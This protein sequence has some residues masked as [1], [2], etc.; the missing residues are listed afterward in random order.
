MAY[1]TERGPA[2]GIDHCEILIVEGGQI[3]PV[4]LLYVNSI[5]P[6]PQR[7]DIRFE[8]DDKSTT[9]TLQSGIDVTVTCDMQDIAAVSRIF[10]KNTVTASDIDWRLFFG[11]DVEIAGVSAGLRYQIS[12]K[13]TVTNPDTAF[14]HRYVYPKG[15]LRAKAPPAA[16]Y[17]QKHQLVLEFSFEKTSEDLLGAA[18]ADVPTGG[19]IWYEERPS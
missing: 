19:A 16:G 13:D 12:A 17:Q 10:Q 4:D 2:W 6:Q 14:K 1:A 15:T 9:I 11:D 8:G 7:D 5:D 18:I 3:V